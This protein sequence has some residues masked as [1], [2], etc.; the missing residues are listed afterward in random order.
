MFED[1]ITHARKDRYNLMCSIV[2]HDKKQ[3]AYEYYESSI[4]DRLIPKHV[5]TEELEA[6]GDTLS[7]IDI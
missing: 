5:K 6:L 7:F 2:A 4:G 3:Q 1:F